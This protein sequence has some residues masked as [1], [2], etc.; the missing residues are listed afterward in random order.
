MAV[1]S[2]SLRLGLYME[3][4]LIG[5]EIKLNVVWLNVYQVRELKSW[6]VQAHRDAQTQRVATRMLLLSMRA[7]QIQICHTFYIKATCFYMISL[8]EIII[9]YYVYFRTSMHDINTFIK[10][11]VSLHIQGFNSRNVKNALLTARHGWVQ[12]KKNNMVEGLWAAAAAN[13]LVNDL[14]PHWIGAGPKF[15]PA[16]LKSTTNHLCIFKW[17]THK[18]D[19]ERHLWQT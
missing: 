10:W 9:E 15:N 7:T 2:S 13:K 8:L 4:E 6:A 19:L 3:K 16:P 12:E 5:Y 1:A 14:S 11:P 17:A 18:D